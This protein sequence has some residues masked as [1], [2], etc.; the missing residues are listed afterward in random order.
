MF[1]VSEIKVKTITELDV[2]TI[3][4]IYFYLAGTGANTILY[5]ALVQHA[6]T[7]H[8]YILLTDTYKKV[9]A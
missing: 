6:F 4:S 7:Q 1:L 9:H 3:T 8:F 2:G 5:F